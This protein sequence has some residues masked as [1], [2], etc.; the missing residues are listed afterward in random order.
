MKSL[1]FFIAKILDYPRALFIGFV[2]SIILALSSVTLLALSAWFISA[3]ALAGITV[4]SAANFNYFIPAA[5]IRFLAL[6]RILSRY[7]DRVINH[8]Y[9][10][11][12]LTQLRVWFYQKLIPLSPA[13]LLLHR[14]GDLLNSVV[15][16]I[17][18][19]DNLYLNIL[20]PICISFLL[21]FTT[22]FLI[23]HFSLP[24]SLTILITTL[25]SFIFISSVTYKYS[26]RIGNNIQKLIS[27]LRINT[28]DFLQGFIDSLL[29][30]KKEE[31]FLP[32]HKKSVQLFY[33]QKKLSV[34]RGFTQSMVQL[35][36]GYCV[37]LVLVIGIPLVQ[38]NS[39][40]G[41]E[42]AMI[43]FLIIGVF[44]QGLSLPFAFLSLGKT[45]AAAI[46][47]S[48]IA[49][50]TPAVTFPEKSDND[51]NIQYHLTLDDVSFSYPSQIEPILNNINL[52][53]PAG[54]HWGIT[55]PSGSGKTTLAYL[56]ARVWD[57]C[58]G[59]ISIG[60][61]DLKHFSE[62]DCR[63]NISL[64]TQHVHIFN[65]SI[66]DNLTL[67]QANYSDINCYHVLEKC[68]LEM[69]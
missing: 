15:N 67:M 29:F 2:L 58:S 30:V 68:E 14:S 12:I 48:A 27:E 53:I 31:R 17:D 36:S 57:P 26:Q 52:T 23:A 32:I 35:T 24:L 8:D 46:R 45:Q 65:A 56:I 3:S 63:A 54:A 19:L 18:T 41:A 44:E 25:T 28:V 5:L 49:N 4:I 39:F 22:T 9:T 1:W 7:G 69:V 33:E 47:L 16:D 38:K 40:G 62:N 55:G 64:I 59:S 61:I 66:R 43:I 37:F 60:D 13:N 20:S 42:L 21:L 50:Q 51:K 10:F 6:I 34:L 11:K